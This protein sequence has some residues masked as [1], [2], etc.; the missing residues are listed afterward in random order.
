MSRVT[1]ISLKAL[2]LRRFAATKK[3][4]NVKGINPRLPLSKSLPRISAMMTKKQ[5]PT[6][7]ENSLSSKTKNAK[8]ASLQ[9]QYNPDTSRPSSATITAPYGSSTK[10][11]ITVKYDVGFGNSLF[12]RGQGAN[13][14]WDKGMP[15]RNIKNDEWVW[16]T[17]IPFATAEFK[18]LINDRSYETGRNHLLHCGTIVQYTP[19]F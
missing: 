5:Q 11:R 16:E 4:I 14:S 6:A 9:G 1:N 13:L 10:T 2:A 12:I 7:T 8:P 19:R 17:D 15:M 3:V 18:V